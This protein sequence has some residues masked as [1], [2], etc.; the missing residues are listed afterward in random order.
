MYFRSGSCFE[1]SAAELNMSQSDS[2]NSR[3]VK[4]DVSC[5][6]VFKQVEVSTILVSVKST[7]SSLHAGTSPVFV[8]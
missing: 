4:F 6:V 3:I 1:H 2:I 7:G 5:C 8:R